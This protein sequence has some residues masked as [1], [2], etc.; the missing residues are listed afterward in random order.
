[1]TWTGQTFSV[2]QV[3]T[4][5]QMTNL[6]SDITALANGDSGAPKIQAAAL[7]ASIVSSAKVALTS[8]TD[9]NIGNILSGG[10]HTL[11]E[12]I[13]SFIYIDASA[14]ASGTVGIDFFYNGLGWITG[15][16]VVDA[17]ATMA[18][19]GFYCNGSTARISNGTNGTISVR[20]ERLT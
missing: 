4:A 7:D 6:Q 2:G 18:V 16:A 20:T 5:A 19:R 13:Y 1:M 3:L 14:A 12:G 11:D 8:E 9:T 10:T 17:G 15:E